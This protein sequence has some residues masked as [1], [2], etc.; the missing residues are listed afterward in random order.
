MNATNGNS[1][2]NWGFSSNLWIG[3]AF[4]GG[5]ALILLNQTGLLSIQF[6]WWAL[7]ILFPAIGSLSSAYNRY[8]ATNNLFDMG[9]MMP[10]LIGLFMLGLMVN[11]LSGNGWDFNWNLFWPAIMIIMGLGMIFGRS[12]TE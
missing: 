7:F 1:K 8:R 3:L 11:L 10:A 9:V 5:G 2:R 6:N 4:I 12:R